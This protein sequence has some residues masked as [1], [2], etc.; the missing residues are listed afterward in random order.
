MKKELKHTPGPWE[1]SGGSVDAGNGSAYNIAMC[2][3]AYIGN[4]WSGTDYTTQSYA[5]ANAHLIASAPELL[6]ALEALMLAAE[7]LDPQCGIPI[8]Y[9]EL[10]KAIGVADVARNKARGVV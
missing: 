1:V 3:H 5:I 9:E 10:C 7:N 4:G 6:A 2:G 8:G